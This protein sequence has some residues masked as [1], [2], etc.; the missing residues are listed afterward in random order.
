M[1]QPIPERARRPIH[2]ATR[3]PAALQDAETIPRALP[4]EAAEYLRNILLQGVEIEQYDEAT[5]DTKEIIQL[6]GITFKR[7][8]SRNRSADSRSQALAS[9]YT[10]ESAVHDQND[11]NP[12]LKYIHVLS[13]HTKTKIS[14]EAIFNKELLLLSLDE[15][16]QLRVTSQRQI[17]V[18]NS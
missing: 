7:N 18:R 17:T 12:I 14:A 16:R 4:I 9:A 13:D 11:S 6:G 1:S 2:V 8:W 5:L 15:N 10:F 3:L